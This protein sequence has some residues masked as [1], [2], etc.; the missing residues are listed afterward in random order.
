MHYLLTPEDRFSRKSIF[1]HI[2]LYPV[3]VCQ[4]EISVMS[5]VYC[6]MKSQKERCL[7]FLCFVRF[8]ICFST[9]FCG[10]T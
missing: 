10:F 5:D 8:K 9:L 4:R 6:K 7:R 1:L 3:S 2:K